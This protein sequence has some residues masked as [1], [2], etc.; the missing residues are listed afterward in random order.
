MTQPPLLRRGGITNR[1]YLVTRYRLLSDG[2]VEALKKI[3]VT[4][5]FNNLVAESPILASDPTSK[6]V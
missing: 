3:D 1:V 4:E 6:G 5:E 2:S